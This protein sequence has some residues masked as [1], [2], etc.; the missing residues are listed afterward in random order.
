MADA[1][2]GWDDALRALISTLQ[3]RGSHGWLVGGS[4]RDALLGRKSRDLDV[5]VADDA[6]SLADGLAAQLGRGVGRLRHD[7]VRIAVSAA[8]RQHLDLTSLGGSTLLTNL[9]SRDFTVNAMALP[10]QSAPKLLADSER[11]RPAEAVVA[12]LIDPLGGLTDLR[13]RRL[14][15]A[16]ATALDADPGRVLRAARFVSTFDLTPVT[17]LA[18]AARQAAPRLFVLSGERLREELHG[19]LSSPHADRG[20]DWLRQV[21]ALDAFVPALARPTGPRALDPARLLVATLAAIEPL[22]PCPGPASE[23]HGGLGPL[24]GLSDLREWYARPLAADSPRYVALAWSVLAQVA[25][26]AVAGESG[27]MEPRL[28]KLIPGGAIGAVARAVT[29]RTGAAVQL[30]AEGAPTLSAARVFFADAP[31]REEFGVDAL[32]AAAARSLGGAELRGVPDD[33]AP[34]VERAAHLLADYLRAPERYVPPPLLSGADLLHVLPALE[35]A[36]IGR[37][38]RA[39]RLA[40]LEDRVATRAETLALVRELCRAE[41]A[42]TGPDVSGEPAS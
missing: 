39:V 34:I 7:T 14:R 16:T 32:V 15:L 5:L 40:Q 25:T 22:S 24:T 33:A 19:L 30:L 13:H 11:D 26:A 8:P 18:V 36:A 29:H 38:L 27:G 41:S 1:D 12:E 6:Y 42:V 23:S 21:G 28:A 37:V 10:L 4:L 2:A 35:G 17:E 31:G 9:A 20:V 3:R